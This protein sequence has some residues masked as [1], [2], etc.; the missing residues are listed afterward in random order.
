M[1]K[2]KKSIAFSIVLISLIVLLV[3][4]WEYISATT[5]NDATQE[6]S[7]S[8]VS[9]N[10]YEDPNGL[11]IMQYPSNWNPTKL[12]GI[13]SIGP[14][15]V[16]FL[17]QDAEGRNALLE[18]AQLDDKSVFDTPKEIADN[19]LAISQNVSLKF[20]LE[21]QVECG[22]LKV[23]SLDTCAYIHTFENPIN[24]PG[25]SLKLSAIDANGVE[26][27]VNFTTDPEFF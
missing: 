26:Y 6:S 19:N 1:I 21:Q 23:N 4:P 27:F 7:T 11:F 13:Y 20:S 25:K 12:P 17:Y 16:S 10:T 9:W 8:D 2:D 5:D 22:N 18:I 15:D 3:N 24:H 14:I